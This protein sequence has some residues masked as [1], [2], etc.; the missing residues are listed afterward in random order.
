MKNL[1]CLLV[2][3]SALAA[4]SKDD[5]PDVPSASEIE[6]AKVR[7]GLSADAIGQG[8]MVLELLGFM[9]KYECGEA[10]SVFAGRLPTTLDQT[11]MGAT[12]TLN[13]GD[14]GKDVITIVF[15]TAGVVVARRTVTGTVIVT[16]SGGTDR[17]TLEV[18]ARQAQV[19]GHPVQSLAGYGTCGDETQYWALSEGP[20]G[21]TGATYRVDLEIAKRAGA[22]IIGGTHLLI[23]GTGAITRTAG[24]DTVTLTDVDYE[25][26][27]LLPGSGKV[28]IETAGG[29]KIS[30]TFSSDTPIAGRAQVTI[31]A[32]STV[33]IPLPGH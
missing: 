16:T 17:F 13:A 5:L 14:P 9:P 12:A 29:H 27:N 21:A 3:T 6:D 19:D 24:T 4:C 32:K 20:L 31:D 7:V 33:T 18:D 10:R 28:V 1:A 8:R 2:L 26:G 30:A 23:T 22:P 15:P 25:I 11:F